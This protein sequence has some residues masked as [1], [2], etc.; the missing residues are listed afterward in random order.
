MLEIAISRIIM[1]DFI[2]LIAEFWIISSYL[3]RNI[4]LLRVMTILGM[5]LYV[6][7]ALTAGLDAS[8][9]KIIFLFSCVAIS[10]NIYQSVQ[11]ILEKKPVFL[12]DSLRAIYT[13][14]FDVMTTREFYK[15]YQLATIK[16]IE[17][18][19]YIAMQ[20]API[21]DITIILDGNV[22]VVKND[23]PL[24]RLGPGFFI[25]EMSFITGGIAT[26]TVIA[27]EEVNA[28]VWSKMDILKLM[29]SNPILY[30]KFKHAIACHLIKKMS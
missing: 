24:I 10:I 3:F 17:K 6:I 11:I 20:N 19:S 18:G 22:F 4:L 13:E 27:E 14:H 21:S 25:G 26:A 16:K 30:T 15:L 5:L 23:T 12:P 9:M 1:V 29:E 2:F 28:I 7:G 8:G